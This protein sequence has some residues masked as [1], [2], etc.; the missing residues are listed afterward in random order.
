MPFLTKAI[1]VDSNEWNWAKKAEQKTKKQK[2]GDTGSKGQEENE[3][4]T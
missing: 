3:G 4:E 2:D 1:F